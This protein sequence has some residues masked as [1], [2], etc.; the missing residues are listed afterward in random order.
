MI[1]RDRINLKLSKPDE[2]KDVI[3]SMS[4][5]RQEMMTNKPLCKIE[6]NGSDAHLW[7]EYLE[8]L[9]AEN[10]EESVRW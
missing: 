5:L 6:D 7:N 10:N 1:Y 3:G 4:K 8:R 2:L 9:K